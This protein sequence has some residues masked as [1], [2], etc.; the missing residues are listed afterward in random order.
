MAKQMPAP[1]DVLGFPIE[2]IGRF[3]A[4][5]ILALDSDKQQVTVALLDWT[6]EQMPT[7]DDVADAPRF[8]KNFMFWND[9]EIVMHL[10][11]PVPVAYCSI[12]NLSL[13]GCSESNSYGGWGFGDLIARQYVWNALPGELTQAFKASL[14]SDALVSAPGLLGEDN[15]QPMQMRVRSASRFSDDAAYRISGDFNM[16]SLHAWPL[17]HQVF[18]H[19]WRDD[20]IPFLCSA[21]LVTELSLLKHD[22]RE[23]DF[24]ATS[25][26]RLVID[27]E[28]LERLVLPKSL[29]TLIVHGQGAVK[30]FGAIDDRV[31]ALSQPAPD[32]RPML[33]VVATQNGR[34]ISLQATGTVPAVHGLDQLRGLLVAKVSELDLAEVV[35]T[36]PHVEYLHLFG[37]PGTLSGLGSLSELPKLEALWFCDL[38]GYSPDDFPA[39][40]ALPSLT[41]LSLDSLPAD[42]AAAVRKAYKKAPQVDLTL[43][44]P[45]KPEWLA[46]NLDNPLRHWDGREGFAPALVKKVHAAYIAALRQ[47][48]EAETVRVDEGAYSQRVT[49]AIATF[50]EVIAGLNR[51]HGF[52]YTLERD[53]VIDAVN[54]LAA[55]LSAPAR[56]A[57]DP[58][59]EGALDD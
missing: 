26:E 40:A 31:D 34:W 19:A 46:E 57:L 16:A 23:L 27:I 52:L 35:D 14:D 9:Q 43:S 6:G 50:L 45:R 59:I 48:R 29:T 36:F 28:G 24:S 37:A 7:L 32:V 10:A 11:L 41:S 3:G 8:V 4:C 33:T 44:K 22:Q 21:P 18:L 13:Q 47:V 56:V 42:V 2:R 49:A 1:G 12:G 5:Q 39:P 30:R 20:L 17:L 53:E 55:S 25:L 38:F 15:D 54:L 51:K 58:L